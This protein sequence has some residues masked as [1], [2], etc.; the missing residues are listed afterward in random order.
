MQPLNTRKKEINLIEE[1]DSTTETSGQTTDSSD[2]EF[3]SSDPSFQQEF[4]KFKS[5]MKLSGYDKVMSTIEQ[6]NQ[7]I[8]IV[9][10]GTNKVNQQAQ[11]LHSDQQ[12]NTVDWEKIKQAVEN[13][14]KVYK[15]AMAEMQKELTEMSK[16]F[17]DLKNKLSLDE[18]FGKNSTQEIDRQLKIFF[19]NFDFSDDKRDP[20]EYLEVPRAHKLIINGSDDLEKLVKLRNIQD[21]F[22]LANYPRKLWGLAAKG[23]LKGDY[24]DKFKIAIR[25][26]SNPALGFR[27]VDV[28]RF[29][30]SNSD[31]EDDDAKMHSMY[32]RKL[33][34]PN[35]KVSKYINEY[36]CYYEM[37]VYFAN[38]EILGKSILLSTLKTYF[39]D[40]LAGIDIDPK[41][42]MNEFINLLIDKLR[43]KK[44]PSTII[45]DVNNL[46]GK[47]ST[48]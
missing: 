30:I 14:H 9:E 4:A 41:L 25:Y 37:S 27:W 38:K 11:Q 24:A 40:L 44:F 20:Q 45:D 43:G 48:K 28:A 12:Q 32:L 34:R 35:Q 21:E 42:T 17:M 5:F 39:K 16:Q 3:D 1:T 18:R 26:P 23:F 2:T 47:E 19:K 36:F 10:K 8:P 22:V 13:E 29:I 7:K 31:L 46:T 33:P 15:A 6:Q